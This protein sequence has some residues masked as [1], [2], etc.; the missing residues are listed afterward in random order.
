MRR[1]LLISDLEVAR[2]DYDRR[3]PSLW[4]EGPGGGSDSDSDL[5]KRDGK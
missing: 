1:A 4:E 5:Y 2:V 3:D